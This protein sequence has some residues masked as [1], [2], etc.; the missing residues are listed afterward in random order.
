M[1][2]PM[3]FNEST[4]TILLGN[5]EILSSCGKSLLP[6]LIFHVMHTSDIT[7][8]FLLPPIWSLFLVGYYLFSWLYRW[9]E[10]QVEDF[11]WQEQDHSRSTRLCRFAL[12]EFRLL[13]VYVSAAFLFTILMNHRSIQLITIC[14]WFIEGSLLPSV[15]LMIVIGYFYDEDTFLLL[16]FSLKVVPPLVYV[17]KGSLFVWMRYAELHSSWSLNDFETYYFYRYC[18]KFDLHQIPDHHRLQ[19]HLSM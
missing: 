14:R 10:T 1:I 17:T 3:R 7:V 16:D 11:S 2:I 4:S 19:R 5:E 13:F 18:N 9:N 12:A 15:S 6:S 8:R